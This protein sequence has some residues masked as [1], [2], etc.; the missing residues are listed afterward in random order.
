MN[1]N[2]NVAIM[3]KCLFSLSSTKWESPFFNQQYIIE[4]VASLNLRM[5]NPLNKQL[6]R[7]VVEVIQNLL[8]NISPY[9]ASF[10]RIAQVEREEQLRAIAENRTPSCV[11]M[12]IREGVVWPLQKILCT[13]PNI[14]PMA[15][16]LIFLRG[17]FRWDSTMSHDTEFVI[18]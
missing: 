3:V 16:S 18:D 1:H 9:A 15:Y 2:L 5:S 10:K 8:N 6:R 14:E 13:S 17:D 12:R 11:T 7:N 4:A